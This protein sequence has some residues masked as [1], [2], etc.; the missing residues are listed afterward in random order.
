MKPRP[1]LCLFAIFAF[2]GPLLAP[3][4][5]GAM[6]SVS[7]TA[8]TAMA[9]TADC[10]QHEQDTAGCQKS[11]P[12]TAGCLAKTCLE[13]LAD[14][15]AGSVHRIVSGAITPADDAFRDRSGSGPPEPPPRG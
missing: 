12:D 9:S 3:A 15:S 4:V 2:L 10:A 7:L 6:A 11:C 5:V 1:L 8:A 13:S 14:P